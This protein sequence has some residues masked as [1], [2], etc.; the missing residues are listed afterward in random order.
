MKLSDSAERL[1]KLRYYQKDEN[2]D[3]LC[4]RVCKFVSNAETTEEKKKEWEKKFYDAMFNGLMIC[5][6]PT[7]KNA[8]TKNTTSA[9][10]V[11]LNPKDSREG[12][13]DT[14]KD[15]VVV[16]SRG[17]GCGFNFSVL[18]P[19]GNIV[20][21]VGGKSS[22]PVSFM[23]IYDL[24]IG[25]TIR[26]G[27]LRAGAMMATFD[28]R[29]PEIIDFIKCK[30]QEGTLTHFNI[31]VMLN[32]EFFDKLE[33]NETV[34]LW[35]PDYDKYDKYDDE[36]D[37]DFDSW[38]ENKKPIKIYKKIKTKEL[39]DLIVDSAYN[40][41]EPGILFKDVINNNTPKPKGTSII[42]TNPCLSGNNWFVTEQGIVPINMAI[43]QENRKP[44]YDENGHLRNYDL[45][46]TGEKDVYSITTECGY[47]IHVTEDHNIVTENGKLPAKEL[48]GKKIRILNN[49]DQDIY[50]EGTSN[51]HIIMGSLFACGTIDSAD[52]IIF[53]FPS[54]FKAK[55]YHKLLKM[56]YLTFKDWNCKHLPWFFKTHIT[57]KDLEF[58]KEPLN[59]R[60]IPDYIKFNNY[61]EL[62]SFLKGFIYITKQSEGINQEVLK[63]TISWSNLNVLKEIQKILLTFGIIAKIRLQP[64]P[65]V[66][67]ENEMYL[68]SDVPLYDLII[69]DKNSII[70]L[71]RHIIFMHDN[72]HSPKRKSYQPFYDVVT[73]IDFIGKQTVYD[74]HLV[75]TTADNTHNGWCNGFSVAN[76]GEQPLLSGFVCNLI[77]IDLSKFYKNKQFEFLFDE[78]KDTVRTALRFADNSIDVSDYGLPILN[79]NSKRYR[80]CGVGIMGWADYLLKLETPYN[81]DKAISIIDTIGKVFQ[82]TL[83]EY[84]IE[85]GKEKENAD[86]CDRRNLAVSSIQPTGSVS[87]IVNTS[88]GIEPNFDYEVLRKDET[89]EHVI[90][91]PIAKKFMDTTKIKELPDYFV[92]ANDIDWK[93]HIKHLEYWQKYIEAGVSKTINMA[94]DVT[95]NEVA[96]AILMA[97]KSNI[98]K[99]LT[100]Y[101]NNSRQLQVLNKIETKNE[102]QTPDKLQDE[103]PDRYYGFTEKIP[104]AGNG[105]LYLTINKELSEADYW[106]VREILQNRGKIVEIFSS[107]GKSGSDISGYLTA[108]CRLI[109]TSLR[110]GGG[111]IED[112]VSTIRGISFLPSWHKG[113]L[114]QSPVDAIAKAVDREMEL[115]EKAMKKETKIAGEKASWLITNDMS[116]NYCLVCGEEYKMVEGCK[117]CSCG[118][119]CDK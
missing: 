87:M 4:K 57:E 95:K 40:N 101:R 5:N 88:S 50:L 98:I 82:D 11:V 76:C 2:W 61:N 66:L 24:A 20:R 10:C 113:K 43:K 71:F 53:N 33:Q 28:Y 41:G 86:G 93:W 106:T 52:N 81:S 31:S 96:D 117:S 67:F 78:F 62:L 111:K 19:R 37:G 35:F 108:I 56:P 109:S 97:A 74:Y 14:L 21:G 39:F 36:W 116:K 22:G 16:Q 103:R 73:K 70:K 83:N 34:D 63:I 15:G 1:L 8:G 105:N 90:Y 92:K 27:G 110:K 60:K 7:L 48:L 80:N 9:A 99:G 17:S 54:E 85:I 100:I 58:C 23:K 102:F 42:A 3:K 49:I 6:S 47:E 55:N 18:R 68:Q 94:E 25:E 114:I 46:E 26:Q 44:I 69:T 115:R 64:D 72:E 38:M 30:E 32:K 59:S 107:F 13:F 79:E 112:L 119:V 65:T 51:K 29:H 75:E 91:H 45:W 104:I 84:S 12:I 118:S 89:G 77:S